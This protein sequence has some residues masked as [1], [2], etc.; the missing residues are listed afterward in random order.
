MRIL[1]YAI[2]AERRRDTA[3]LI[4]IAAISGWLCVAAVVA[5]IVYR[6]PQADLVLGQFGTFLRQPHG[7]L[8]LV[9]SRFPDDQRPGVPYLLPVR[10]LASCKDDH[11]RNFRAVR[12]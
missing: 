2:P 5:A 6:P 10:E 4:L 11:S 1:D 8:C 3:W 7:V 12:C 9:Y